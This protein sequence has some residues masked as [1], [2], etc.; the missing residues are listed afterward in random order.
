MIDMNMWSK[1]KYKVYSLKYGLSIAKT[2][3]AMPQII[4]IILI[5]I[6]LTDHG[7]ALLTPHQALIT[8]DLHAIGALIERV[9]LATTD[10]A[11]ALSE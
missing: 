3:I 6:D 1:L 4:N 5:G 11:N 7:L 9:L 2:G 10:I 8:N